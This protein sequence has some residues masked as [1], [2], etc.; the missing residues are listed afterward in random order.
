MAAPSGG[1]WQRRGGFGLYELLQS[2]WRHRVSFILSLCIT[3]ASLS[4]YYLV[5]LQEKRTPIS[6]LAERLELDTL[7]TRFRYRSQWLS[8]RDSSIVRDSPIVIVDIDQKAQEV[9]GRWPFSRA[10]FAKLLDVLHEDGAKVAAFDIT[11]SKP[12][13][14]AAPVRALAQEL[15]QS[16]QAGEDIDPKLIAEV[17]QL[18]VKYD[19]DSQFAAAIKRFGP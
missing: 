4:V 12:D 5:F 8:S 6:E 10:Y 14:T 16:K 13:Q 2:W 15:D 7:D 17:R 18:A 3:I 11:F 1:W 9:L 19:A